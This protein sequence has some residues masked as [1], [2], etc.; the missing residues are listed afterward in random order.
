MNREATTGITPMLAALKLQ[1]S[2][3]DCP[4]VMF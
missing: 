1:G 2:E 3:A 4:A